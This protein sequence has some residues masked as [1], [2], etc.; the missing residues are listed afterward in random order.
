MTAIGRLLRARS[1]QLALVAIGA[2]AVTGIVYAAGVLDSIERST[3][4]TRFDLRGAQG[5]SDRIVIVALDPKSTREI[6][7]RGQIPR[8]Y[9]ARVLDRLHDA[10]A[11]VLAVDVGFK[12]V[13]PARDDRALLTAI[14]RDGPVILGT[15]DAPSSH[16]TGAP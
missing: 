14:A 15:L 9:Y 6:G 11:R 4:D 5:S 13:G 2:A 12:G 1:V 10:G 7:I 16:G 3:I 8:S